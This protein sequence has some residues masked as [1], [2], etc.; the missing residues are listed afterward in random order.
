MHPDKSG[1][2]SDDQETSW[3][4]SFPER[5]IPDGQAG[6]DLAKP[7]GLREL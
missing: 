5:R 1:A 7:G 6:E 4:W 2:G 3:E